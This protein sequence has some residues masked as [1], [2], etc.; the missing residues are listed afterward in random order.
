MQ[1]NP[2][3]A[4]AGVNPLEHFINHGF[5]EGRSSTPLFDRAKYLASNPDVA[6]AGVDPFE[7]FI[8]HG[9][10]ERRSLGNGIDLAAFSGDASF[11]YDLRNGNT[12]SAF[13]RVARTA[14]FLPT[15]SADAE[16]LQAIAQGLRIGDIAASFSPAGG[17]TLHIP[18]EIK[19]T[20]LQVIGAAVAEAPAQASNILRSFVAK[21][22]TDDLSVADV[23]SVI[24]SAGLSLDATTIVATAGTAPTMHL[25]EIGVGDI[26]PR[27]EA[28]PWEQTFQS[29]N[30][31]IIKEIAA[32]GASVFESTQLDSISS[33]RIEAH[34]G[35]YHVS[36]DGSFSLTAGSIGGLF[37]SM[38]NSATGTIT[39]FQLS[40]DGV[41]TVVQGT[42]SPTAIHVDYGDYAID[43][44]GTLSNSIETVRSIARTGTDSIGLIGQAVLSK[45]G[46]ALVRFGV[47]ADHSAEIEAD[48]VL[49]N[50]SHVHA[51]GTLQ[52]PDGS[53]LRLSY[54]DLFD[55]DADRVDLRL[56]ELWVDNGSTRTELSAP[57][58]QDFHGWE[59]LLSLHTAIPGVDRIWYAV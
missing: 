14:V 26:R 52:N 30:D 23:A 59:T 39:A 19:A 41:G 22:G 37:S 21:F 56:D 17:A 35:A 4:A 33:T 48:A 57:V 27:I 11:D 7:H 45:D 20:V 13:E 24:G 38:R 28:L 18:A 55:I 42:M 49:Q 10:A 34:S 31:S 54:A 50:G 53:P 25:L 36:V 9:I 47:N 46:T 32:H 51:H 6:A 44:T 3:V 8:N 43:L 58:V 16:E 40:K 5:R 2:D 12:A 15:F 1:Q 29:A